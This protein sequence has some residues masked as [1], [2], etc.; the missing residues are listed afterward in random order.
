MKDGNF[1]ARPQGDAYFKVVARLCVGAANKEYDG[2]SVSP[3]KTDAIVS[4]PYGI[5]NIFLRYT[6]LGGTVGKNDR[7]TNIVR[8]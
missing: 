5:Q 7:H 8:Q 2:I 6:V 1:S 3:G 4:V